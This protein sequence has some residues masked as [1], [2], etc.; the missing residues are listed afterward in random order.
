[1]YGSFIDTFW[2]R[3]SMMVGINLGEVNNQADSLSGVFGNKQLFLGAG[4][5]LTEYLRL[6]GG[7]LVYKHQNPNPLIREEKLK[8]TPYLSLSVDI[9][10]VATIRN[11]VSAIK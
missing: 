11:M 2:Q 1:M 5:R 7:V 4:L 9:D 6:G 8:G 3:F 10:A